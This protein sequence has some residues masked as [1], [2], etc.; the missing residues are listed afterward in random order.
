LR[1]A[2]RPGNAEWFYPKSTGGD[3]HL[4][5]YDALLALEVPGL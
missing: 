4:I 3:R 1:H 5:N 2:P